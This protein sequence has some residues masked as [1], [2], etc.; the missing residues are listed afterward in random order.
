[1]KSSKWMKKENY[2]DYYYSKISRNGEKTIPSQFAVFCL[3][4][5]LD[6]GIKNVIEFGS[7]N[8]R[9]A[10]FLLNMD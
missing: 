7:G 5:M 2:W 10:I 1:M 9:D 3:S 8:G 4:E 6:Q